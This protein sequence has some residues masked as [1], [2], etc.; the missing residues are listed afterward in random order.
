MKYDAF[1]KMNNNPV[2]KDKIADELSGMRKLFYKSIATSKAFK[3]GTV[4]KANMLTV[5]KPGSGIDPDHINKLIGKRLKR[6][7]VPE[8]LLTWEDIDGG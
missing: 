6:D 7:V 2:S 3:K 8:R 5:K 4:L 1:H